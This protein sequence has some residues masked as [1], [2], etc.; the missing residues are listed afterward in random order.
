MNRLERLREAGVSIW[1]DTLSRDFLRF[2]LALGDVYVD[3]RD[4]NTFRQVL[5]FGVQNL[6]DPKLDEWLRMDTFSHE[7]GTVRLP[8]GCPPPP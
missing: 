8:Q 7:P 1:L 5:Q 4:R 2:P 3:Q 6:Y